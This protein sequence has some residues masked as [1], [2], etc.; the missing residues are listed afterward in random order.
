MQPATRKVF[1]F[2]ET[3]TQLESMSSS[4]QPTG[5]FNLILYG[6]HIRK[7]GPSGREMAREWC[8]MVSRREHPQLTKEEIDRFYEN[9]ITIKWSSVDEWSERMR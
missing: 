1:A 8:L 3:T 9:L 6:Q 7:L 4:D 5:R 2:S